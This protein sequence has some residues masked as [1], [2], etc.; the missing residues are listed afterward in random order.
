MLKLTS[1]L[2]LLLIR[3]DRNGKKEI[4]REFKYF[5]YQKNQK[6]SKAP[7]SLEYL[8]FLRTDSSK[9]FLNKYV[10]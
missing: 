7:L 6:N 2:E 10:F 1:K 4:P 9:W 5:S 3:V 8:R